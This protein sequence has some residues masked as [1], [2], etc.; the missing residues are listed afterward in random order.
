[1]WIGV[2][3]LAWLRRDPDAAAREAAV[4]DNADADQPIRPAP[5]WAAMTDFLKDRK[6]ATLTGSGL[7]LHSIDDPALQAILNNEPAVRALLDSADG[8]AALA[9]AS[10]KP[11]LDQAAVRL[12]T[13]FG[14]ELTQACSLA[15]W[16]R[17]PQPDGLH[18]RSRHDDTEDCWALY[19]HSAVDIKSVVTI[20]ASVAEHRAA[21]KDAAALWGLPLPPAWARRRRAL[22][23]PSG[24]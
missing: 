13:P 9:V 14:R 2:E 3:S 19:D 15:V 22:R 4:V 6:V 11:R 8:R 21:L 17:K 18:Y 7:L 24:T 23:A 20:S 12:S 16:D 5:P 10:R 1:M